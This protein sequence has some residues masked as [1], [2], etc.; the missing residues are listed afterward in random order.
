MIG[1]EAFKGC[2]AL[3]DVTFNSTEPVEVGEDLFE[4]GQ[5]VTVHVNEGSDLDTNFNEYFGTTCTKELI[6][7]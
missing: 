3:T 1:K 2:T 4:E 7:D 6:Q 5:N